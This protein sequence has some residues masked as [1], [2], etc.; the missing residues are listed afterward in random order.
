MREILNVDVRDLQ[1]GSQ[2]PEFP[3]RHFPKLTYRHY[4]DT[5]RLLLAD[6]ETP[7]DQW[8]IRS[9]W[10]EMVVKIFG[11]VPTGD[12]A[13]EDGRAWQWPVFERNFRN[14]AR[15]FRDNGYD[16]D[17]I[18]DS[19]QPMVRIGALGRITVHQGNKRTAILRVLNEE[20]GLRIPVTVAGRAKEW[21][22]LV[23]WVRRL[24]GDRDRSYHPMDHPEFEGWEVDQPC[25]ER[26]A[27]LSEVI[28]VA[29]GG[30]MIDIGCHTGW[31]CRTFALHGWRTSGWD[32]QP[33]AILLAEAM[34]T[35]RGG[36]LRSGLHVADARRVDP[37]QADVALVLSVLMHLFR[38][39]RGEDHL[40]SPWALLR[41]IGARCGRMYVD[42]SWGAYAK[43]LPFTRETMPSM[44]CEKTGYRRYRVLGRGAREN[45]ELFEFSR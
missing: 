37:P 14:L 12:S 1:P 22:R 6:P 18:H 34:Q 8:P 16:P 11:E 35:W 44:I 45:R 38:K 10:L 9:V 40:P 32:N 7:A 19:E 39:R 15:S 13:P 25:A 23:K 36:P 17:R 20:H 30:T 3:K 21:E 43:N 5:A 33:E 41:K 4:E 28:D 2:A 24:S 42:C 26:F 31:F 29:G 27:M